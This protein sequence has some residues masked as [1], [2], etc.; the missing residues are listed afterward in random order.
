MP[1]ED[2]PP[3]E[4]DA[5]AIGSKDNMAY[6]LCQLVMASNLVSLIELLKKG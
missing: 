6:I 5:C 3:H 1:N 4:T 2:V